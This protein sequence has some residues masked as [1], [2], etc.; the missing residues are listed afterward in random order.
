MVNEAFVNPV[1]KTDG[2]ARITEIN[3]NNESDTKTLLKIFL[4]FS[5][6]VKKLF[7]SVDRKIITRIEKK[8]FN[9]KIQKAQA[10]KAIVPLEET[11]FAAR[12]T[13]KEYTKYFTTPAGRVTY[14][15]CS[16]LPSIKRKEAVN[17]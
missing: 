1:K 3:R 9:T 16:I 12:Y 8:E 15:T 2:S 6:G 10:K 4:V 14:T 13:P 11:D 17:N 5:I 7:V